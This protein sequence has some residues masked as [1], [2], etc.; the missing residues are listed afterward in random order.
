[1]TLTSA[2][3]GNHCLCSDTKLNCPSE[4]PVGAFQTKAER[5]KEREKRVREGGRKREREKKEAEKKEKK[6]Q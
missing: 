2:R 6:D 3:A 1:M 4:S 5:E